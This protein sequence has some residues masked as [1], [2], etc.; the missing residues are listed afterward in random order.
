MKKIQLNSSVSS[1]NDFVIYVLSIIILIVFVWNL[2]VFYLFGLIFTGLFLLI[3]YFSFFKNHFKYKVIEFDSEAI[4]FDEIKILYN[5]IIE[6]GQG[7][8]RYIHD[9]KE[10]V[11]LFKFNFFENN[12]NI[13]VNYF[14]TF[15]SN[16]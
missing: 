2:Y 3:L 4:Y 16:K 8:I 10:N 15:K 5:D 13:L 14:N 7:K 11:V 6:I 12:Y 1:F 9:N